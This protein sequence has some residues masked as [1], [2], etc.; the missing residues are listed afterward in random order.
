MSINADITDTGGLNS[1]GPVKITRSTKLAA[2]PQPPYGFGNYFTDHLA[3]M[4]YTEDAGWSDPQVVPFGEIS[5][6]P[7]AAGFQY[8]QSIFDA[9]KAHM[10]PDGSLAMFRPDAHVSRLNRSAARMCIPQVDPAALIRLIERL[11]DVDRRWAPSDPGSAL[12]VRPTIIATEGF[13]S[14]RPAREYLLIVFLSPVGDF[15][16]EGSDPIRILASDEFVRAARGGVGSAKT[17]GNYAAAM[18]AS[19]EAADRGFSQILWLDGVERRYLE[20]VGSMN[21][22]VKIAG[23]VRTPPLSDSILAGVTRDTVLKLLK[24]N[25]VDCSEEPIAIDELFQAHEVGELDEVWGT[26]TAA[27]ISPIGRIAYKDKEVLICGGRSGPTTDW[28]YK[29]LLAVQKGMDNDPYGWRATVPD[30]D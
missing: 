1:G 18:Y 29:K 8:S 23:K 26:G 27:I 22:F 28:L 5:L 13:V 24:D 7:S 20:E 17:G 10:Q 25:Q 14:L 11:C 15:F 9:F 21:I 4:R 6:H 16:A 3:T 19:R 12:Y 2:L 30:S